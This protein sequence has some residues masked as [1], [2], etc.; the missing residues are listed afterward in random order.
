MIKNEEGN[1]KSEEGDQFLKESH[2]KKSLLN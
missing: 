1:G 2:L